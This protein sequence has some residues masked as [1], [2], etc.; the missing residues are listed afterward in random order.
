MPY[1]NPN[2][3]RDWARRKRA[4]CPEINF[5][6]TLAGGRPS[7]AKK[8]KRMP[9]Q[10]AKCGETFPQTE[11][12]FVRLK[13]KKSDGTVW[14]GWAAEC[15]PCRNLRFGPYYEKN[16]KKLIARAVASTKAFRA[17][18]AGAEKNRE[19][20]REAKRRELADPVKRVAHVARA[21]KWRADNPEKARM[22]KHEQKPYKAQ[23]VMKRYARK[24]HATPAWA[25]QRKIETIYAIADFLTKRTGVLHQ[26]DHYYPIM[27][28]T[29]CGLHVE[30]NLR[31]IPAS[32]NQAKGNRAPA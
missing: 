10:C 20:S 16:Q 14:E 6:N 25:D 19:W 28:K 12:F 13:K 22:F 26:V 27:G 29:S 5:K 8:E 30:H 21:R 7:R 9:G 15:R 32:E 31:V 11:E 3:K 18:E 23:R 17:T 2:Y 4:A 24:V 1:K